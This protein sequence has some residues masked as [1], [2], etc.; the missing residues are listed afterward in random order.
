MCPP[1]SFW[2]FS[3]KVK[4]RRVVLSGTGLSS[5]LLFIFLFTL[6]LITVNAQQDTINDVPDF[7]HDQLESTLENLGGDNAFDFDDLGDNLQFLLTHP[8]SLNHADESD[9]LALGLLSDRQVIEILNYRKRLGPFTSI[10]ELQAVPALDP[11]TI[12]RILPFVTI[13]DI[14]RHN[15]RNLL[16]MIARGKNELYLRT[17]RVLEDQKGFIKKS[18]QGSSPFLG[19]PY[20]YYV[21]FKHKFEQ[22]IDY[23][24]T[25]EN[26]A[27]EPFF[28][29]N[30]NATFDYKSYHFFARKYNR[31]IKAL[32][33][34]DYNVSLG[35]G[36]IMYSG[37]RGGK[38][39]QV[40][41]IKKSV[42]TL[43]PYT[44]VNEYAA[45]RGIATTLAFPPF[46]CSFFIS[47]RK[48]DGNLQQDT[49]ESNQPFSSFTSLQT[50]GLH[51]TV[52]ELEDK[53]VVQHRVVGGRLKMATETLRLGLNLVHNHFREPLL[54]NPRPYNH[55]YFRGTDLS[56]AS[57]DYSFIYKNFNFFGE[58]ALS[59]WENLATLNGLLIG[60]GKF[61]DLSIL[62]R[63][64]SPEYQAL[65]ASAFTETSQVANEEGVY[66]GSR[67]KFSDNMWF[68]FYG[69]YWRHP[70]LRF[71]A[72]AP[73][74]GSEHFF[75]FT[76]FKKRKLEA[77]LQY[78]NEN[79][80]INSQSAENEKINQ[81]FYRSRKNLRCHISHKIH[82][83]LELRNRL[84]FSIV[85]VDPNSKSKGIL[86][87]QD[88]LY[89]SIRKPFS[90][91]GRISYFDTDDFQSRIYAYENDILYSFSIPAYFNQGIRYYINFR[92]RLRNVT[93]ESRFE[94][95]QYW[96]LDLIG[97]GNSL[98]RDNKKTRIKLQCRIT[99]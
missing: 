13:I 46:E 90:F 24:F 76:Y 44:S 52:G 41:N 34:G 53:D 96:N 10:Y 51:R 45:L 80:A 14:E 98:I 65:Q 89:R 85:G 88:V 47:R 86:I 93:L 18:D 50:S 66:I 7:I 77:Y 38:G 60:L 12:A 19:S 28:N 81:L 75:R 16:H 91:K 72:D 68:S 6:S 37:Y 40:T 67:V 25:L 54:Q 84:E 23:G 4:S 30:S 62:Y 55:F 8:L 31:T 32:A 22:K 11:I 95:T 82:P 17:S 73:S 39:S 83:N 56:N 97:S 2:H 74:N 94:Q 20:Q 29:R 9:L 99:F 35:E 5:H 59:G 78:K 33:L 57:L 48:R 64:I 21:R 58:T 71:G 87:Y 61:V 36:L 63:N 69:D 42:R 15:V 27:G 49:L 1:R 92:Y 70:W 43:R 26:D 79:K 3:P